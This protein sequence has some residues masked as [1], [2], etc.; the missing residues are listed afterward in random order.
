MRVFTIFSCAHQ[1]KESIKVG[2]TTRVGCRRVIW[3]ECRI[4]PRQQDDVTVLCCRP[5]VVQKH[6]GV[7]NKEITCISFVA[8]TRASL[9]VANIKNALQARFKVQLKRVLRLPMRDGN[10]VQRRTIPEANEPVLRLPMRDGN[11]IH[12]PVIVCHIG[13]VLRLP[14]RDG[15]CVL[16]C[17]YTQDIDRS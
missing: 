15:N 6:L 13:I 3:Q 7:D 12:F 9:S 5:S 17:P 14:M 10:Q 1:E 16:L 8:G 4:L 2:L 11:R